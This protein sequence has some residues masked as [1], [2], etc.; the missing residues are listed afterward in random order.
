MDDIVW[1]TI[2]EETEY[3]LDDD[4]NFHLKN[5]E[6]ALCEKRYDDAETHAAYAESVSKEKSKSV[7]QQVKQ[8]C[9]IV[10][11]FVYMEKARNALNNSRYE[12]AENLI[13]SA[14]S[15]S[16]WD[17]NLTEKCKSIAGWLNT[18]IAED[19]KQAAEQGHYDIA[20]KYI[21]R[22]SITARAAGIER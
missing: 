3:V 18:L 13:R 14:L 7:Q 19:A 2:S 20:E 10:V 17:K 22:I 6:L 4:P 11:S 9:D 8:Q 1:E 21:D 12:D 15:K 5:A 16:H